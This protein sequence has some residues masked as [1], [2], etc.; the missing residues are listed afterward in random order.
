M[1]LA[2]LTFFRKLLCFLLLLQMINISVD[3]M[4]HLNIIDGKATYQEDLSINKVESIYELIVENLL[5]QD[6]PEAQD[7][8]QNGLQKTIFF[9]DDFTI[10]STEIISFS[11]NVV[12]N[13]VYNN[14]LTTYHPPL[15]SPPP[16]G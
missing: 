1:K 8:D 9:C 15:D 11:T 16:K 6:V 3:P 7:N 12:H 13:H 14:Q 4:R 10:Q 2:G 5:D